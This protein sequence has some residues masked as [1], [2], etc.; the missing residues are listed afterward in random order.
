[1]VGN[2][3]GCRTF[4]D[5]EEEVLQKAA[6]ILAVS[7]HD[8][9]F[10]LPAIRPVLDADIFDN[11][12]DPTSFLNEAPSREHDFSFS[13]PD[14]NLYPLAAQPTLALSTLMGS[15]E[16]MNAGANGLE[17]VDEM[18]V[19]PSTRHS[20]SI[21]SSQC[22]PELE[23]HAVA[24]D[25]SN[26]SPVLDDLSADWSIQPADYAQTTTSDHILFGNMFDAT[27]STGG[28][29]FAWPEDLTITPLS[30][31][32]A[33]HIVSCQ[34][35]AGELP[36]TSLLDSGASFTWPVDPTSLA[37]STFGTVQ[38][39]NEPI[40]LYAKEWLGQTDGLSSMS[41]DPQPILESYPRE[42]LIS[43]APS[44]GP[45]QSLPSEQPL[46]LPGCSLEDLSVP[47]RVSQEAGQ[48]EDAASSV[49]VQG[50]NNPTSTPITLSSRTFTQDVLSSSQLLTSASEARARYQNALPRSDHLSKPRQAFRDIQQ[51]PD[52]GDT[53]RRGACARCRMQRVRVSWALLMDAIGL[54]TH[55]ASHLVLE[56]R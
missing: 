2:N 18:L 11:V 45:H 25:A 53:R 33:G 46:Q 31:S 5:E 3:L 47:R 30:A 21:Q 35:L 36:D 38:S 28:A 54:L 8:L 56:G 22:S 10:S 44:K 29:N 1:M 50:T 16:H 51:R 48:A 17:H 27:F 55:S 39:M 23:S 40:S 14:P 15:A 32:D 20:G 37:S 42:L 26:N 43:N 12:N 6:A 34:Q 52:T 4:S 19:S 13:I 7:V 49:A 41:Y 9:P 24:F